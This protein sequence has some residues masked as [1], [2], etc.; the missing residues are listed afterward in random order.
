MKAAFNS[1]GKE[2]GDLRHKQGT[3]SADSSNI[4]PLTLN[5]KIRASVELTDI[6]RKASF[7]NLNLREVVNSEDIYSIQRDVR[8]RVSLR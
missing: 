2:K 8:E 1:Q 6:I 4:S 3:Y 5:S 7:S